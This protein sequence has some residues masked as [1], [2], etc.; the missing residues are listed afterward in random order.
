MHTPIGETLHRLLHAYKRA[1]RDGYTTAGIELTG[2]Q[3]RMIKGIA[4]D[5]DASAQAIAK[6]TRQDKGHIARLIKDLEGEDL[7]TRRPH[8]SDSRYRQL[9]LTAA[10]HALATRIA[11]VEAEAGARMARHLPD[12]DIER[13]VEL[14]E[15]MIANLESSENPL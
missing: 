2:A 15:A 6:R 9:K 3:I 1:M 4:S 12:P 14:A 13:F 10:G 7:I 5:P 8:P 11:E